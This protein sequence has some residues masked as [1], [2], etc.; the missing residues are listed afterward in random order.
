M[1]IINLTQGF[2]T[3]VDDDDY[4]L[5]SKFKWMAFVCE[6][7]VYAARK[8][9]INKKNRHFFMHRF[10]LG[11]G[12]DGSDKS[13]EVDHING[14][15]L[16]NR[17]VNLRPCTSQQNKFNKRNRSD[18]KSGYKGVSWFQKRNRWISQIQMSGRNMMIGRFKD[19]IEAAKSYDN[20]ARELFGDFAR[21]NFPLEVK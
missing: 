8:T 13:I 17:K 4:K 20:K 1:K 9:Y 2:S 14:S 18:N 7:T 16:D 10:I 12:N 19:K 5:L 6:H 11:L 15:G 21:T 3:I